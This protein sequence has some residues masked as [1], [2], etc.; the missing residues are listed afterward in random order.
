MPVRRPMN[1]SLPSGY[2]LPGYRIIRRLSAGGFGVVYLAERTDGQR[3]ALKEFLPSM[4]ACRTAEDGG[5]VVLRDETHA[6]RFHKGL[7]A[8][9]READT[10]ARVHDP[11]I[12][13]VW[14]VFEANNTAYLAMPVERGCTFQMALRNLGR[15]LSD[16]QWATLFV[17]AALGVESL[18]A[19]GLLHLDLKPN[20]LWWRPDGTVVVLDLGASRWQEEGSDAQVARTPGYAAPEQHRNKATPDE[21]KEPIVLD[22]LGPATDV[23]GLT[24]SLFACLE[25]QPPPAA[26]D[27]L[28]MGDDPSHLWARWQ[29]VDPKQKTG[30]PPRWLHQRL[31][32]HDTRLMR[33]IEHGLAL[34]VADRPPTIHAWRRALEGMLRLPQQPWALRAPLG[35]GQPIAA[36]GGP[37]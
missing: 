15:P 4:L 14:D 19:H 16:A 31:G 32:Q 20:N 2:R 30:Q 37:A 29:K 7:T 17:E 9:F 3:V 34:R 1:V 12:I 28:R 23:Y 6:Q 8:F 27:R 18:H 21:G 35:F 25:G 10:L 24:A 26:P 11:R 5:K 22:D 13:P 33:L 36:V